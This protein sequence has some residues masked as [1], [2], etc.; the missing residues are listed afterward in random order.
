MTQTM[1]RQPKHNTDTPL[2]SRPR[3]KRGRRAAAFGAAAVFVAVLGLVAV[4]TEDADPN[5]PAT[6]A[7]TNA[8]NNI[9]EQQPILRTTPGYAVYPLE[10]TRDLTPVVSEAI[11]NAETV[12]PLEV[13]RDLT[14]VVSEAINNP[15]PEWGHGRDAIVDQPTHDDIWGSSGY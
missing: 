11:N 2:P 9:A 6:A 4:R 13:T 3:P 1:T 10:V 14:P 8:P 12:N 15:T 7:A 5:E